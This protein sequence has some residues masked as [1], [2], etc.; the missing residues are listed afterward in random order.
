MEQR[1]KKI[2]WK[3]L[4]HSHVEKTSDWFWAVGIISVAGAVL[5]IYFGNILFGLIIL[6]A[7]FTGI[8]Q[9]HTKPKILKYEITRKGIW[10][11]E[12][13]YPYS[14]LESFWVIDEEVNDRILIR[15]QKIFMPFIILPYES[16]EINP[17]EI[18]D[19]LLDYIDEEELEE[20]LSQ[21]LMERLG[22]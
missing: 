9:G 17:D 2:V 4:E 13:L 19:Y 21:I 5:A 1:S 16:T 11:G 22:F 8:L 6:L 14:T 20:P 15:S 12:T 18:R 10:I 3:A 7:A